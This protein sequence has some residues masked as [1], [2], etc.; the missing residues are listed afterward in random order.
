VPRN[1]RIVQVSGA[2]IL[3]LIAFILMFCFAFS[4][5]SAYNSWRL[6]LHN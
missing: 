5:G 2:P 6:H 4:G 3:R 1:G